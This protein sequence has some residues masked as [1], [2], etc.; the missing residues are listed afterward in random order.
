LILLRLDFE[1]DSVAF[2]LGNTVTG[3]VTE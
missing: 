2:V 1:L 3:T